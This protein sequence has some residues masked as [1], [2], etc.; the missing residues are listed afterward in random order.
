METSNI[1]E[2][3]TWST[4]G[5]VQ[6]KEF[7]HQVAWRCKRPGKWLC[8]F[9][10]LNSASILTATSLFS[11]HHQPLVAQPTRPSKL[12]LRPSPINVETVASK[13]DK[14]F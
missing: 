4:A 14:E 6:I 11:P 13:S 3:V 8:C 12:R 1:A 9:I 5:G 10:D 2:V 7:E